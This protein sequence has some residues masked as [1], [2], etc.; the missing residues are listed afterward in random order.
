[1]FQYASYLDFPGWAA[2]PGFIQEIIDRDGSTSILEVGGGRNPTLAP[3]AVSAQGLAYTVNDLD[4]SEL[5]LVDPAYRRLCFDMSVAL[6]AEIA[7]E[8]FDLVFSR[9]VN[10]HIVDG[11]AYYRNIFGLLRP[12]GLT[13]HFFATFYT[14]PSLVNRFLP[15]PVSARLKAFSFA[16]TEHEY[17]KFPARYSWCRGPSAA[18][19]R[20]FRQIGFE[21]EDYRGYFGH[22]Y[23]SRIRA[24]HAIELAKTRWL[25]THPVSALTSYA[26]LALRRPAPAS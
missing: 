10:E 7:D 6:P 14:M 3:A 25:I 20:R 15:E 22:G 17:E 4:Q 26:V 2:A 11:E 12:G 5:D 13:V 1:M 19:V 24:L 18:M 23:Y 8:H 9:M 21:V 16:R